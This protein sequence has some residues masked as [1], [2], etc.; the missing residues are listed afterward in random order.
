MTIRRIHIASFGGLRDFDCELY[1]GMNVIRGDNESGKTS[2]AMFIKFIF[3]GLSGRSLDGAPSERK[4]YVNWDTG[5]AEGYIIAGHEGR[6][7]RI[8]RTLSVSVRAGSDKESV[9]ESLTVTDTATGGRVAELEESPG[10]EFFGVPEQVFVNTVFSGQSGRARIDGSD[11][12]AAVENILFSADETVNV[13]KAAEKIEKYRRAL[14]HKKGSG[15]EIP[16]LKTLVTDTIQS[17]WPS[18]LESLLLSLVAMVDIMMVGTLGAGAITSNVKS[19]K[20]LVVVKNGDER[21]ET[22]LKKFGAMIGDQVEVGCNSVLNPGTVIGKESHIYPLSSVRGQ[23]P[24]ES[25]YKHR[26]E[27]VIRLAVED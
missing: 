26:G 15:G 16:A 20:K 5:M 18:M 9:R 22:G 19:D 11:T 13:K 4:K 17:A 27:V 12:A 1:S 10:I 14:L 7:Y 25:I 3:Y 23:V 21:M 8:E 2:L 6:E 24:A